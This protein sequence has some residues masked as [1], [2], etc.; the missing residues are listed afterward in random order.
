MM[1]SVLKG[2]EV[3]F[4]LEITGFNKVNT[5]TFPW[6]KILFKKQIYFRDVRQF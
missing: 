2:S 4:K 3:A 6:L 5:E 1:R